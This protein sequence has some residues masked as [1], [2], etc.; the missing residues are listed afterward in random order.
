MGYKLGSKSSNGPFSEVKK[1]IHDPPVKDIKLP[2]LVVETSRS[3]PKPTE[4]WYDK[5]SSWVSSKVNYVTGGKLESD[6]GRFLGN[7]AAKGHQAA[8][9]YTK[10]VNPGEDEDDAVRHAVTALES[11][12]AISEKIGGGPVGDFIGGIGA[13][14]LG[15]GHEISNF[16]TQEGILS[17]VQE[18]L[19]DVGNN[20][21]GAASNSQKDAIKNV[22]EKGWDGYGYNVPFGGK[23]L[24]E[25]DKVK[26][27]TKEQK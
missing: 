11:K 2:E 25:K 20:A 10:G 18:L 15:V 23:T 3:K 19:E 22:K 14:V 27:K 5:A 24:Y 7:P 6:V 17:G 21:I 1:T 9:D 12:K 4:S 13:N 26:L 8:L 16:N